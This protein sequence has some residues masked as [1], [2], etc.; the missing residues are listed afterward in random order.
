MQAFDNSKQSTGRTTQSCGYCRTTGHSIKDCPYIKYDHDEWKAF[1]VPHTSPTLNAPIGRWIMRDY[2]YWV[3]Q[4]DKYYPKWERW[5][6]P[7]TSGTRAVSA[8][9]RRCGFCR[10]EGHTRRD[11]PEMAQIYKD[12]LQANRNYRQSLYDTFV[13]NLGIGVGAVLKVQS[14][15]GRWNEPAIQER[16]VTVDG[17]DMDSANLFMTSSSYNLD[18][19]YCGEIRVTF[20]NEE[21]GA[22]KRHNSLKIKD[23]IDAEGRALAT[24]SY[25]YWAQSEYVQ[26]I[27]PS[28]Q[29]LAPEWVDEGAEAFEWLL[30]KRDKSWLEDRGMLD[31][32]EAWK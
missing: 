26:T 14:D 11:C 18:R 25:N 24:K 15:T 20:L 29:P 21:T 5:Q 10:G 27:A 31:I 19:D 28:T 2:S 12:L 8:S 13:T 4:I 22:R 30:K 32:I 1:R 9:P 23:M 3:K 6:Q 17:F 7:R 16:L